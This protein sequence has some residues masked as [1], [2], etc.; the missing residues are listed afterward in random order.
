MEHKNRGGVMKRKYYR[1]CGECGQRHE[2]S[3][4]V[5][6]SLSDNGWLCRDCYS[7][8]SQY[9]DSNYLFSDIDALG[10]D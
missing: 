5:R 6:T 10:Q 4:M 3:E 1:K 8:A 9:D 7:E 2:Q